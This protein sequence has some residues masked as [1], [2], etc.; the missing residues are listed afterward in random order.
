[1]EKLLNFF[2]GL[3]NKKYKLEIE[4]LKGE[5]KK[6]TRANEALKEEIGLVNL[7]LADREKV[8]ADLEEKRRKL[9]CSKGGFVRTINNFKDENTSLKEQ[10]E[11]LLKQIEDFKNSHWLVKEVKEGK[12]PKG[13]KIRSNARPIPN[14]VRKIQEELS[15]CRCEEE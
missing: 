15:E 12:T 4:E 14:Q 1:M 6:I 10:N 9:S 13:Q 5:V 3:G 8:I 7:K 2:G 11:E